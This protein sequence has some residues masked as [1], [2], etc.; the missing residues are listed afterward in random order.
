MG[1][2][3]L[4]GPRRAVRVMVAALVTLLTAAYAWAMVDAALGEPN[5]MLAGS[6]FT[7]G[8]LVLYLAALSVVAWRWVLRSR[9]ERSEHLRVGSPDAPEPRDHHGLNGDIEPP[10]RW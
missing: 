8:V 6:F 4:W 7:T 5:P 1:G 3:M 10:T 9:H 2:P